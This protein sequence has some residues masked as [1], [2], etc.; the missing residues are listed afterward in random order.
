MAKGKNKKLQ[1]NGTEPSLHTVPNRDLMLRMNFLYQVAAY[2][3]RLPEEPRSSRE[4]PRDGRDGQK[5]QRPEPGTYQHLARAHIRTMRHIGQKSMVKMWDWPLVP[6]SE[7][8]I[9]AVG[10]LL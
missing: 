7:E 6:T 3:T 9:C 5:Q 2:L 10:I 4:T 1:Q 8:L